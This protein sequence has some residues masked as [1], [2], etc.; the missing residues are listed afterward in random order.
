ML[1]VII[2]VMNKTTDKNQIVYGQT[3]ETGLEQVS[4]DHQ[5]L[6]ESFSRV[7][8]TLGFSNAATLLREKHFSKQT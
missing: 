1:S 7:L 5:F 6:V 3:I 4:T 8:E 2:Q